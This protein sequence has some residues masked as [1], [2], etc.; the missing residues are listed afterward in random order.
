LPPFITATSPTVNA[1]SPLLSDGITPDGKIQQLFVIT[2]R[3]DAP[4]GCAA[5]QPNFSALVTANNLIFRQTSPVFGEG[6]LE[7]IQNIDILTSFNNTATSRAAKGIGG[8]PSIADDGSISRFGWKAQERSLILFSGDAYNGEEGITN[9]LSLQELNTTPGCATN[10]LPEDHT[11]YSAT[12]PAHAFDGDPQDLANFMRFLAAPPKG[13]STASTRNGQT[14]FNSI[15]CN[16]CHTVSFK[17]PQADVA[18]LSNI[19]ISPYTDL[20]VHHMGTC[21]ADNIVQGNVLGDEFRSAPLWGVSQRVFFM[22][23]GRTT[24]I[25]QAIEDH[26]CT[27]GGSYG[28]SEANTVVNGFNSLSSKNQ[29]DLVNFLRIL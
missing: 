3:S 15:G 10:A 22:H 8:H 23:D 1:R 27:A 13:A 24:N 5:T 2:G 20:M 29:Q 19:T 18:A 28:A 7:I 11:L 14:Q 16:L 26:F 6:L 12:F 21:L 9:E 4:P 17:T 25:V